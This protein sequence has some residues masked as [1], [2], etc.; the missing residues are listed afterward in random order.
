VDEVIDV[1]KVVVE[2]DV[3]VVDVDDVVECEVLVEVVVDEEEKSAFLVKREDIVVGLGSAGMVLNLSD[4][5]S[6]TSFLN[7]TTK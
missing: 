2:V 7:L 6:L 3:T 5:N 1:D 4:H